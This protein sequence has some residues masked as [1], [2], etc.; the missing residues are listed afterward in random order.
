MSA[1]R[2]ELGVAELNAMDQQ[3]FV[4]TLGDVYE[5]TP[6]V[7][8]QAWRR[9]PFRDP[10]AVADA[11]EAVV[12]GLA[13]PDL[14]RLLRAHPELGAAA[15]EGRLS[16]SEQ[17]RA[18]LQGL[19]RARADRLTALRDRY[20]LRFGFPFIVAVRGLG[21]DQVVGCLEERLARS[22]DEERARALDQVTRIAWNRLQ[23]RLC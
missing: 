18:G 2:G 5:Q 1:G 22:P 14:L 9:R 17:H 8:R 4:E 20:R 16:R 6:D 12:R 19:D 13:E 3:T 11:M 21:V 7:A 15:V 10:A 23:D